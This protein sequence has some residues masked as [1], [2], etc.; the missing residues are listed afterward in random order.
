M[1]IFLTIIFHF[2]GGR[3]NLAKMIQKEEKE[4]KNEIK[5]SNYDTTTLALMAL[6]QWTVVKP[7]IYLIEVLE[8]RDGT[9]YPG[10]LAMKIIVIIS[11]VVALVALFGVAMKS[12]NVLQEFQVFKKFVGVKLVVFLPV[13]EEFVFNHI[14]PQYISY[15]DANLIYNLMVVAEMLIIAPVVMVLW[16]AAFIV[17]KSKEST[18]GDYAL[19]KN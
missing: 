17:G 8:E 10:K 16:D 9:D 2:A 13:V 4:K 12:K 11:T 15:V 1:F 7:I 6:A 19:F 5:N 3:K 14:A 18:G